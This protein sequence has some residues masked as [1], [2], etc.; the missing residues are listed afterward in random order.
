MWWSMFLRKPRPCW[1]KQNAEFLLLSVRTS[2]TLTINRQWSEDDYPETL[3]I[4]EQ[5][6]ISSVRKIEQ[7][8]RLILSPHPSIT[9]TRIYTI[10]ISEEYES[11]F[12]FVLAKGKVSIVRWKESGIHMR[13]LYSRGLLRVRYLSPFLSEAEAFAQI[14]PWS[15]R[16]FRRLESDNEK[17][18]IWRF[19][20]IL[21]RWCHLRIVGRAKG[22]NNNW[23]V[24]GNHIGVFSGN[25]VGSAPVCSLQHGN[26]LSGTFRRFPIN[27]ITT[28]SNYI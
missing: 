27:R 17:D 25:P 26:F 10:Q 13:N 8:R 23:A 4:R 3:S 16:N 9:N 6:S 7:L 28:K 5:T 12:L 18:S 15:N 20:T 11:H 19:P 2:R 24:V 22:F 1:I 14:S 21:C